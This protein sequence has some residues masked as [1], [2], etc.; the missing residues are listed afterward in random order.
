MPEL[1]TTPMRM[2]EREKQRET[3][4]SYYSNFYME[5]FII[6]TVLHDYTCGG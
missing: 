1:S 4:T 3:E 2:R 6:V 5:Y